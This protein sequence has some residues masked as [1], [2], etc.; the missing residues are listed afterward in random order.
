MGRATNPPTATAPDRPPPPAPVP[1]RHA[2]AGTPARRVRSRP[3]PIVGCRP[4]PGLRVVHGG[5][6][7][8]TAPRRRPGQCGPPAGRRA[9]TPLGPVGPNNAPPGG[10][11]PPRPGDG[12]R[13]RRCRTEPTHRPTG[14]RRRHP[15]WSGLDESGRR[16]TL[17]PDRPAESSVP[18]PTG[19]PKSPDSSQGGRPPPPPGPP[20][21]PVPL[22]R[23]RTPHRPPRFGTP[24][25]SRPR[26]P[27][28]RWRPSPPRRCGEPGLPPR[29]TVGLGPAPRTN[30]GRGAEPP[31]TG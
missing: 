10:R 24:D 2:T 5:L 11:R 4:S 26:V 15:G 22:D 3:L 16:P 17:L 23:R 19:G 6:R 27:T 20:H 29:Q 28:C 31:P 12:H 14:L 30:T 7:P 18:P 1:P 21:Q 25:V 8:P 9:P 13:V